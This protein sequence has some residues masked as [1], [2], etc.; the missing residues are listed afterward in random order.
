[1]NIVDFTDP[2]CGRYVSY[3]LKMRQEYHIEYSLIQN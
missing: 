2:D 3:L 1:M